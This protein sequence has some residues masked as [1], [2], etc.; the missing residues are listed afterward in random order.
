M[1]DATGH[2]RPRL[3]LTAREKPGFR[4]VDGL[5]EAV[6]T[7][8]F[9]PYWEALE[10]KA[11]AD[12]GQPPLLPGSLFPGRS[13]LHAQHG[14][15]DWGIVNA[16]S[17][18]V[19]YAALASLVTGRPVFRDSALRQM[20]ALFDPALWPEWRDKAH[21]YVV[22][23]LRTGTLSA[24][25]GLAYDWLAPSLD[26]GQKRWIVE[27]IDRCGIQS[28][29][30]AARKPAAYME[31]MTNW[32]TCVVGGLG[33]CGMA[34]G[35]DHPQSRELIDLAVPR[36]EAYL[37]HYGPDG[38][39]NEAVGYSNATILAVEFFLVHRYW[40]GGGRNVLGGPPFPQFGRWLLAMTLPPGRIATLGD[41]H[42]NAPPQ[43]VQCAAIAAAGRDPLLQGFWKNYP[44]P[45]G[46]RCDLV[47]NLL[48][49]DPSVPAQSP[50]GR[51]PKGRVFAAHG[52]VYS[53][54][55]DWGR[56][57]AASVVYGK[58]GC[59]KETHG[60]HD[61]GQVCVD[62]HGVRLITD[63]G[64]P[65]NYPADFF[66]PN[67]WRYHN[68]SARGHNVLTF[69]GEDQSPSPEARARWVAASFDDDTGGYWTLDLT[70]NYPGA[71]RVRRTMIH[72]L[73]AVVAVLDEA[74][75]PA[76]RDV[77][78]RWHTF[79]RCEPDAEGRF[80]V[81]NGD[82]RLAGRVLR[83]DGGQPSLRRAEHV[84]EPPF[85]RGR[86]GELLDQRRES[87]VE[88]AFT[89]DR[90]RLLTLFAVIGPGEPDSAWSGSAGRWQIQTPRGVVEVAWSEGR[91]EVAEQHRSLTAETVLS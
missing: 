60:H 21:H 88:A 56:L 26:A 12:A 7:P 77:A 2:E 75:L 36:M 38:E 39:F 52:M 57:E 68:A 65:S 49:P 35:E 13:P 23:D 73:P 37:T 41:G 29:L 1:T 30:A 59:G 72:L 78:L 90:V 32:T 11:L 76:A 74:E 16:V 5:R 4:S 83:L 40:S 50:A 84:Y 17:R 67:R 87:F 15:A 19:Q 43:T 61:A 89:A 34:L 91:L 55:S 64:N 63:P 81:R 25:L 54:R 79:D 46:D 70:G 14:N 27:G 8:F 51:L 62:G 47:K 6:T 66:G 22:A 58:G 9:R 28:Y 45:P 24:A 10:A 20:E 82:V 86:L 48:W 85:D 42:H 71:T 69:D 31:S 80:L 44:E 53:S 18:R 3:L 33:I